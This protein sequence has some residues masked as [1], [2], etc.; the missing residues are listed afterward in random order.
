V[1]EGGAGIG[2]Y[3]CSCGSKT[4]RDVTRGIVGEIIC[5]DAVIVRWYWD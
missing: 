3:S 1:P 5:Y 2:H 4:V